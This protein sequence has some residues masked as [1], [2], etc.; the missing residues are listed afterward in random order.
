MTIPSLPAGFT[1]RTPMREDLPVIAELRAIAHN[2]HV[3]Y[4]CI[5]KEQQLDGLLRRCA[6]PNFDYSRDCWI[7]FTP[8]RQ[9]VGSII[10]SRDNFPVLVATPFVHPNYLH[11]GLFSVLIA[12]A[13]ER[14]SEWIPDAPEGARVTLNTYCVE[15]NKVYEQIA[16]HAGYRYVR[17]QFKMEIDLLSQPP[18]PVWPAGIELRPFDWDT[19]ALQVHAADQEAFADHWGHV[20]ASFELF[21]QWF[22]GDPNYDPTLYFVSWDGA[23]VTGVLFGDHEG[24]ISGL[25]VRRP[26]RRSGIAL[27]L[28]HHAFGEYFRRGTHKVILDVDAQSL[29]GATRLYEK[30]GMHVAYQ[31]NQY[32]KILREGLELS[33]QEFA[34]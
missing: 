13:E 15:N 11:V 12:W 18:E 7:V 10:L 28:L 34:E 30:A 4:N 33:T 14:A 9:L 23:E 8:D 24:Y 2:H 17:S 20:P 5:T 21:S 32:Q 31:D 19:Q 16:R 26:W 25:S 27:A 1:L 29:T 6:L 3:G 22:K